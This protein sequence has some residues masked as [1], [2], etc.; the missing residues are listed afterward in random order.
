M[1]RTTKVPNLHLFYFEGD[2][3]FRLLTRWLIFM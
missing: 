3:Q 1:N 2:C